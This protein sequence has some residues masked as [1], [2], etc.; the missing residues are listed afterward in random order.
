M[1]AMVSQ[2]ILDVSESGV[3]SLIHYIPFAGDLMTECSAQ[4][5][6]DLFICV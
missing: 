5:E 2:T 4:E 1:V 3:S 6:A